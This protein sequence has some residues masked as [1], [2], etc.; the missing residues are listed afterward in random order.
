MHF[1][2]LLGRGRSGTSWIGQILNQYQ[3]CVYKYEP[4]NVGKNEQ[5]THWIADLAAG[6]DLD[7]LRDRFEA[8][9]RCCIHD[10]DYPPFLRKACRRQPPAVLRLTWQLGKVY[11]PARRVYEWYGRPAYGPDDWV[12]VK[13][14][15]FPNEH[16]DRLAAAIAP[17]IVAVLRNPYASVASSLRFYRTNSSE[18]FRTERAVD[19]VLELLPSMQQY[20]VPPY[21]RDELVSMPDAAFEALRWRIQSEPLADFATRYERGLAVTHERFASEPQQCAREVFDFLHW[22][23]DEATVDRYIG[24]TTA[25]E[26]HRPG[27][28]AQKQMHSLYRDPIAATQRWRSD[29]TDRQVA[30]IERV[31]S[32]SKLLSMW[33]EPNH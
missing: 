23:I 20:G 11:P 29:L 19:R 18:S 1:A 32:G 5:F 12:L 4:F 26:R 31:V 21:G 15:N 25:G 30:E 3:R 2:M 27:A 24:E 16:L 14:V 17:S 9:C 6:E 28:S 8:L 13:Q 33:S 10:V 7:R 22:P